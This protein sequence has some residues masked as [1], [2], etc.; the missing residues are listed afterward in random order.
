MHEAY[1]HPDMPTPLIPTVT[2]LFVQCCMPPE[3]RLPC[4][5][6]P[7]RAQP[8]QKLSLTGFSSSLV[9]RRAMRTG[10]YPARDSRCGSRGHRLLPATVHLHREVFRRVGR[11]GS[12]FAWRVL[13]RAKDRRQPRCPGLPAPCYI[14]PHEVL[15]QSPGGAA[16]AD[17]GARTGLHFHARRNVEVHLA[18]PIRPLRGWAPES[19]RRHSGKGEG[20]LRRGSLGRA[21]RRRFS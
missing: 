20:T 7:N 17:A 4:T 14:S 6:P 8:M 19:V 2:A 13:L 10:W 15:R 9:A 18:Q 16:V 3:S 11:H 1:R 5:K 21:A 12:A